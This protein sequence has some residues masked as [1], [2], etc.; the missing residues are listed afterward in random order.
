MSL[1]I[2]DPGTH[3]A[4]CGLMVRRAYRQLIPQA[5][6]MLDGVMGN[7]DYWRGQQKA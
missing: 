3:L 1:S 5:Q 7:Y 6:P 4:F 2:N